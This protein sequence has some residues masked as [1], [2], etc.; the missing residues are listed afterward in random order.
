MEKGDKTLERAG[1][2]LPLMA[3]SK[4]ADRVAL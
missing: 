2:E 4:T 3:K 1:D